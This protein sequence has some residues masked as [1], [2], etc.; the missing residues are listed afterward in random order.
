MHIYG[1][2]PTPAMF[3]LQHV[4]S[5]FLVHG[6][7]DDAYEVMLHARVC[8]APLRFGAGLKGKLLDA[9]LCGTP[10]VTTS[11]GAEGMHGDLPWNGF[12]KD[13][14]IEF[15]SAAV[16]L[17]STAETWNKS[18][19]NG[20]VILKNNFQ[21]DIPSNQFMKRIDELMETL[22]EH[23]LANFYGSILMHH[24]LKSTLYMS[25]WI[26]EKNKQRI[27]NSNDIN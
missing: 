21:S 20:N 4:G 22:E 15:A 11:I 9:M 8:L 7:T 3:Q 25:R 10:S 5:G 17:Y 13:N 6:R 23:R 16:H 26:Q 18:V 1:A 12:V 27:P 2:Y 24:S 14:P 19:E